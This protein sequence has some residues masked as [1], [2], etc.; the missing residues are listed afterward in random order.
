MKAAAARA[1]P[2]A[3]RTKLMLASVCAGPWCA[4]ALMLSIDVARSKVVER[5][6]F[7]VVTSLVINR[8][9]ARGGERVID[10]PNSTGTA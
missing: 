10:D 7:M 8:G 5:M 3:A 9:V 4:A 1:T 6:A 2:M